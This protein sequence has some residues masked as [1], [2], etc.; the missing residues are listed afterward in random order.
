MACEPSTQ[1]SRWDGTGLTAPHVQRRHAQVA[2]RVV[3]SGHQPAPG[4]HAG[5]PCT[6]SCPRPHPKSFPF[7]PPPQLLCS[8]LILH[9]FALI[10]Q[11]DD[12]PS[13]LPAR[14]PPVPLSPRPAASAVLSAVPGAIDLAWDADKALSWLSSIGMSSYGRESRTTPM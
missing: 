14:P 7:S 12:I 11:R 5:Q 8:A 3:Q 13:D 2:G 1:V 9:R 4:H 10:L 6:V